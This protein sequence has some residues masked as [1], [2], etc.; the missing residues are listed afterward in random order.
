[1]E[2]KLKEVRFFKKVS[3]WKLRLLTGLSQS[4]ISLIE[5]GYVKPSPEE[6]RKISRALGVEPEELF[7]GEN[8]GSSFKS[9]A[10]G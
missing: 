8:R 7:P 4:K 10:T 2:N 6:R 9:Q 1:M 3:Q 5:S